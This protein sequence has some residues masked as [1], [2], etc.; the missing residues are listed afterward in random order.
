M[1]NRYYY[2]KETKSCKGF[3]YTGCGKSANRFL[4][5]AECEEKYS[6]SISFKAKKKTI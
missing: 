4:T 6:T 3:H 1:T 2:N 5:V